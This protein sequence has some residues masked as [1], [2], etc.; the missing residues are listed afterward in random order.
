MERIRR[1]WEKET[2]RDGLVLLACAAVISW[3]LYSQMAAVTDND[4][5][6]HLSRIDGIRESLLGG[7]FPVRIQTAASQ[8]DGYGYAAGLFYPN[9]FLY[10]SVILCIFG[11]PLGLVY[12]LFCID[13]HL[14]MAGICPCHGI[15]ARSWR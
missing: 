3:P 8:L 14:V 5:L 6:F 12:N 10:I 13:I 1:Y 11:L 9:L 7:Q 4:M 15:L 2:V